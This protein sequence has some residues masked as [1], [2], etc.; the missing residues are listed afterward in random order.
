[1]C[2]VS[3]SALT[4]ERDLLQQERARVKMQ[5]DDVEGELD[6]LRE[7][8]VKLTRQIKYMEQHLNRVCVCCLAVCSRHL[9]SRR[10]TLFPVYSLTQFEKKS[11]ITG[12]GM[13]FTHFTQPC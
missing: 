10:S 7:S 5:L 4:S 11:E 3:H 12:G 9:H 8:I 1:M 13:I 6:T 2:V